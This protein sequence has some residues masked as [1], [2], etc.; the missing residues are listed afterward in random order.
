MDD[1]GINVNETLSALKPIDKLKTTGINSA[2]EK[3]KVETAK[4]FESILLQQLVSAMKETIEESSIDDDNAGKQ[5]YDMFYSFLSDN[6]AEN[7]GLGIWKEVYN[8]MNQNQSQNP[9]LDESV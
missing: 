2:D 8:M 9:Y 7:G 3:L 1:I 4:N 6:M 5:V